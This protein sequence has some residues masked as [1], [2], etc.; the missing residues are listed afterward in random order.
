[1]YERFHSRS[2]IALE[3]VEAVRVPQLRFSEFTEEWQSVKLTDLLSL[4]IDNRGKTPPVTAV[5]IPLIETNAIGDRGV[6]FS[7]IKKY[8]DQ[9]TYDT[10]FRKHLQAGD[11]LFGTVGQTGITS[12]Y[13]GKPLAA[14]AQNV[15]GL[16][17]NNQTDSNFLYYLLAQP[18]N[19]YK[20]KKIEMIAVQPSVKVSQMIHL[21][22]MV[23]T[24][25]E[26]Q[27][28]A[29]VLATVDDKVAVTKE[30]IRLWKQYKKSVTQKLFAQQVR[31]KDVSGKP[32][33]AWEKKNIGSIFTVK[34]GTSK[35][36]HLVA[37]GQYVIVDMGAI[38]AEAE[39]IEAKTTNFDHDFLNKNELV[40]AKDDIGGGNI[41]GK[42][43]IIP[44]NNRYVCG[45]HV[46]RLISNTG[47]VNFM[48]YFI[49]SPKVNREFRKKANGTAQL[50]ITNRTVA[51]QSLDF[52]AL[53]EQQKIA[54][55]LQAIDSKVKT[56]E[57]MLS[58]FESFKGYLL[59]RMFV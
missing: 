25:I 4:V 43:V 59:H 13:S 53:E 45:D 28:I 39:L 12:L 16:R 29:G 42:V 36:E 37:T 10:W 49:N 32:Y 41:I 33:P 11:V 57:I 40:M 48:Y 20:F 51:E 35:S 55:F 30:K 31:F 6:D 46:Y 17:A 50:G 18:N 47:N 44:E 26:Q 56:E 15:V 38:S 58:A 23:P 2:K 52:P 3:R 34:A 14:I 54:D 24:K 22:F 1:L 21:E 8:V 7:V 27:Q 19:N 5:G 9:Q